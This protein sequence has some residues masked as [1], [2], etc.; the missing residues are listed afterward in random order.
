[1]GFID[2]LSKIIRP[3]E[4]DD[5]NDFFDGSNESGKTADKT[6]ISEAQAAFEKVFGGEAP[7]E[8]ENEIEEEEEKTGTFSPEGGIFGSL[9]ARRAKQNKF[10]RERT[11]SFGGRDSQVILFNPKSFDEAGELVSHLKAGRSLVMTLEGVP[12]ETARRLLDFL[13]GVTFALNGKITPV[14]G[15]TYFITPEN[16]DVLSAQGSHTE[17]AGEYL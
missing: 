10:Q 12:M 6:K 9:G 4:D 11:V 8:P 1:M 13:S 5:D 16:V 3:I 14:S 17:S 15:K 2:G 7:S